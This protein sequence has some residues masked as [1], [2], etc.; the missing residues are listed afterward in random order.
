[1]IL[2]DPDVSERERERRVGYGEEDLP[3]LLEEEE[4]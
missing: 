3:N 2:W 1:M 4:I